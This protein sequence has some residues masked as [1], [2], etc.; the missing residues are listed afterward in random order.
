MKMKF[1][2]ESFSMF[3]FAGSSEV[4]R[5]NRSKYVTMVKYFLLVQVIG[6]FIACAILLSYGSGLVDSFVS[7]MKSQEQIHCLKSMWILFLIT[8]LVMTLIAFVGILFEQ[9]FL[10]FAYTIYCFYVMFGLFFDTVAHNHWFMCVSIPMTL[11]SLLLVIT[12]RIERL[13]PPPPLRKYSIY[14]T[15]SFA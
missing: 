1:L 2:R 15:S 4:I 3:P 8:T 5:K 14:A 6:A 7:P 9:I 11:A 10:L 12:L 13:K